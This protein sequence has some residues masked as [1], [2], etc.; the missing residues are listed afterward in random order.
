MDMEQRT[1]MAPV[2]IFNADRWLGA[3]EA[4]GGTLSVIY[5]P[6]TSVVRWVRYVLPRRGTPEQISRLVA[7]AEEGNT[8]MA[9]SMLPALMQARVERGERV[10]EWSGSAKGEAA[11]NDWQD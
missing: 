3:W 8:T 9:H 4:A 6:G 10:Q 7:L 5:D 2:P 1:K 11:V